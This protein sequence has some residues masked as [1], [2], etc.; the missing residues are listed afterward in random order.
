MPP[1]PL[2]AAIISRTYV[3][4]RRM[5]DVDDEWL[6]LLVSALTENLALTRPGDGAAA[7]MDVI[8]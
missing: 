2:R 3:P 4:W 8:D 7:A 5:G 1:D 6:G